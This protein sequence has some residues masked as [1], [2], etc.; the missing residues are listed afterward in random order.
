MTSD[1]LERQMDKV[2]RDLVRDLAGSAG[3]DRVNAVSHSYY[4]RLRRDA[5]VNDFIP[6]LVYRLTKEELVRVKGDELPH[7]A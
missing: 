6:L 4:D 5:V 1:E 2:Y 7:A 3:A